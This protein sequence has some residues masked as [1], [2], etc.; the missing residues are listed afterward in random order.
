[1]LP[2]HQVRDQ[3]KNLNISAV[4]LLTRDARPDYGAPA[5]GP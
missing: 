1:V 5:V 4:L 2:F 3:F